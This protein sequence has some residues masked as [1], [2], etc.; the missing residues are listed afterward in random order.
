MDED[1]RKIATSIGNP[2]RIKGSL[3]LVRPQD[4][5]ESYLS[6]SFTKFFI[7]NRIDTLGCPYDKVRSECFVTFNERVDLKES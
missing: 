4:P 2:S 1:R 5:N 3:T 7:I 6:L